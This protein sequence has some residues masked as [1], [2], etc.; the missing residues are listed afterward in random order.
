M[1]KELKT[2]WITVAVLAVLQ[3]I[4]GSVYTTMTA[5]QE[6]KFTYVDCTV[7]AVQSTRNEDTVT[8]EG[9]TV[10]YRNGEGDTVIAQMTDYPSS[11][12][13]GSVF[14]GRYLNDP[15]AVSAQVTDWFTPVFLIVLGVGYGLIDVAALLLRKK[16]GLY[17]LRD[18][19]AEDEPGEELCVEQSEEADE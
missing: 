18:Y 16:M 9:V 12:E 8:I 14:R 2:L 17:A 4:G 3:I 19:V 6:K 11:F 5:V 13:I 10:S 7:I 1:K 15:E